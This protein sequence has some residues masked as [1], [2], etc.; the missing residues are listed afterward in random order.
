MV[1]VLVKPVGDDHVARD[2]QPHS[3]AP[4]LLHG[5]RNLR[6][7]VVLEH[8]LSDLQPHRFD[9]R[10]AHAAARDD[11]IG[12]VQEAVDHAELVGDLVPP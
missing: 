5:L 1:R 11:D 7:L 12:Y 8:R 4:R 6:Q 2:E 10:E 3:F 9:Y